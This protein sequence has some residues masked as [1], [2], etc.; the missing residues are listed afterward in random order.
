VNSSRVSL[1]FAEKNVPD[2]ELLIY[3]EWQ[4]E[5]QAAIVEV[6]PIRLATAEALIRKR[7]REIADDSGHN[8]ERLAIAD[9]LSALHSLKRQT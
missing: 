2:E 4:A 7:L 8:S 3:P 5:F 6:D 1:S 9:A